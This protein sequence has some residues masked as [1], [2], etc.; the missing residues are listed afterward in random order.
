MLRIAMACVVCT[1]N[2]TTFHKIITQAAV[3]ASQYSCRARDRPFLIF[4]PIQYS[5]L[6]INCVE[7]QWHGLCTQGG[8]RQ[9][10]RRQRI[11]VVISMTFAGWCFHSVGWRFNY[12]FVVYFVFLESL[13]S[14]MRTQSMSDAWTH[15]LL[16][17]H[18]TDPQEDWKS[19]KSKG[20]TAFFFFCVPRRK[21]F[22]TH[23]DDEKPHMLLCPQKCTQKTSMNSSSVHIKESL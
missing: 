14:R 12:G 21:H 11:W 13:V 22:Q 7:F 8:V 15:V 18:W 3:A 1:H 4:I 19:N 20:S 17:M 16:V 6:Q 9:H 23:T 2:Q 5:Y 10:F